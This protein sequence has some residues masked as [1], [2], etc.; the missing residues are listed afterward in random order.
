MTEITNMKHRES[1]FDVCKMPNTIDSTETT[2]LAKSAFFGCSLMCVGQ[3][4]YVKG[5]LQ[6]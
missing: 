5:G 4:G 6:R 3:N 2:R 1:Q